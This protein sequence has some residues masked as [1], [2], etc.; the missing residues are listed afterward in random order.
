MYLKIFTVYDQK[1]KAYLPP[2]FLPE[3]GMAERTFS[4]CCNDEHHQFGKHPEDYTL[5]YAGE[6]SDETGELLPLVPA[7]VLGTGMKYVIKKGLDEK[8]MDAF[9]NTDEQQTAH[10]N[11]V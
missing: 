7:E 10:T 4:D 8:Q 5:I 6:F 3:K 2:F 9:Q 11:G 1:A